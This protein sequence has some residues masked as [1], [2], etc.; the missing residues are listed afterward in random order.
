MGSPP[1]SRFAALRVGYFKQ[2]F[3]DEIPARRAVNS[4]HTQFS[5]VCL[6]YNK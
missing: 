3:F 1:I 4:G 6:R 2:W 5:E